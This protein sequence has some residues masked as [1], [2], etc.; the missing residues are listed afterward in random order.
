MD[1]NEVVLILDSTFGLAHLWLHLRRAK[2]NSSDSGSLLNEVSVLC[3]KCLEKK[4]KWKMEGRREEGG[5]RESG[6]SLKDQDPETG[7]P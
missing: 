4:R 7:W 6:G 2:D 1:E 5:G 3:Y